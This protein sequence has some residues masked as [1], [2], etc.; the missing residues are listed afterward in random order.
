MTLVEMRIDFINQ[1]DYYIRN[2]IGDEEITEI[3]LALGL[4]DG[5]D[6]DEIRE[7]AEDEESWLDMV[8]AFAKCCKM[9]GV[10]D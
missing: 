5:A 4:P 2:E 10:M 3:W 8:N 1:F 7:I 9:A 6:A